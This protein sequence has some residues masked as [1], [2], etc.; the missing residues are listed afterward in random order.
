MTNLQKAASNGSLG[1]FGWDG[2]TGNYFMV[3]PKENLVMLYMIQR[4]GGT[5]PTMFGR[6]RLIIYG[7]LSTCIKT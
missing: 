1:E 6:L 5:N 2:W 7:A 3:D 4:C